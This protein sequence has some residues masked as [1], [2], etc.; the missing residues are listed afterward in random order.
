VNTAYGQGTNILSLTQNH[1]VLAFK[2]YGEKL[3]PKTDNKFASLIDI[4]PTILD[5]LSISPLAKADGI[6]LKPDTQSSERTFFMETGDTLSEIETDHI[7]IEKVIKHEIGIYGISGKGLLTM[8]PPAAQSIIKNKQLA[9]FRG[10]WILAHFPTSLRNKKV[11]PA[12]F[13]LANVKTGQWTV[14]LDSNFAKK[15]PV[16]ALN[17]ELKGFYGKDEIR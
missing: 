1:V 6:S 13:V 10:D 17:Q 4:A 11:I 9:I 7:Y 15:S 3:E 2:R 5:I 16:Q 12:Y 14:E 8:N